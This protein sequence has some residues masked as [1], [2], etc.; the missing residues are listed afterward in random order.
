MENGADTAAGLEEML[1][2]RLRP[3]ERTARAPDPTKGFDLPFDVAGERAMA[4][5]KDVSVA[6]ESLSLPR[7]SPGDAADVLRSWLDDDRLKRLVH[8]LGMPRATVEQLVEKVA[9]KM[10]R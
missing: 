7:F 10:Q 4:V 1:E 2:S 5:E 8:S 9:R 6:P 3:P